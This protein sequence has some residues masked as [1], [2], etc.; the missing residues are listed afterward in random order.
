LIPNQSL[1][2]TS[3]EVITN[4]IRELFPDFEDGPPPSV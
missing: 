1:I 4:A 3:T 2:D